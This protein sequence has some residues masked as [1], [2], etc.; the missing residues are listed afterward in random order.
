MKEGF[1]RIASAVPAVNVADVDY[2]VEHIISMLRRLEAEDVEI[3]VMPEL[4]VTGYTCGDLFHTSTLLD[5]ARRGL[6]RLVD[7]SRSTLMDF[8]VGVPVVASGALYN[9][10]AFISQGTVALTAKSYIPN[11]NEFY[12]RRWWRPLP[13]G[14][15]IDV[16]L[17]DG[18][19]ALLS[20]ESTYLSHGTVVGIEICEDLWSPVPP[21]CA[22][23]LKGARV[24]FNLSAS[25]DL[26]GKY[27]YLRD[28]VVQQSARLV[29]AYAYSSA[30]WGESST[31][32]T[33]DGKALIAEN[34]RLLAE[35]PRWSG[36]EKV[37][38]ADVD[39]EA[40]DRDRLH[41]MTFTDCADRLGVERCES[42]FADYNY[43][44]I[45]DLKYREV[46]ARPFV[47]A[48][49]KI[50]DARC[51][52][53]V[54]IQVAALARRLAAIHCNNLTVGISG[55]LDSTLALLVAV[56][57]FD[58]LG[59]DRK[60][61]TG[62]TMPGFGTTKRTHSNAVLLME[63]LGITSREISI[64]AAVNRHFEDIGH[65]PAVHD[66]TYE[67]SQA[68]ERTQILMDVANQTGGI[69]LGTGDLSELA[70]GWA[71][72]NGDHMSMY[73]VNA[74]VPKTLVRYL[75]EWFASHAEDD[76][77]EALLD[78]CATP[79]SPELIPADEHGNITQKTEDLVGPYE[80]H[81][82]VLYY[83]LRYGFRPRRI[84]RLAL[85]ALGSAYPREEIVKWMQVFY[86]RF[87]SQ[88][89]KRSCMPDGPKVGSVCLS[90]RGDWRMPSDASVAL[91]REEAAALNGLSD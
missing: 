47:P 78:I 40:I 29:A 31:D 91:W 15:S 41:N 1:L 76:V 19:T 54:N 13:K 72:Y 17:G 90:P 39:I 84:Y 34:G 81:D 35:A 45:A 71:T 85:K 49:G 43:D 67:N 4:G 65:D 68:R 79:I 62:I 46:A 53:I 20:S 21:S 12:E 69:V 9:C 30:G 82:F 74:G 38:I 10:A 25:D 77:R 18:V 27:D 55:G 23:A 26:I 14:Q 59:I 75:V 66:V 58:R 37:V 36:D 3:A 60:G 70:L 73:G 61:I 89:F 32:L 64:A 11:Y 57:T 86:R 5:A 48:D 52:E 63:R 50:V 51:E 42:S 87:F 7:Y 80:L 28:L 56:K 8:I 16:A 88:Q 6:L 22:M 24:I 83:V 33:F 44:C 2:N